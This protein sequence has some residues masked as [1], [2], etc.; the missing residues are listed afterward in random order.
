MFHLFLFLGNIPGV[1]NFKTHYDG[2]LHLET[3][4]SFNSLQ[5]RQVTMLLMLTP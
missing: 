5:A 1:L 4:P 3:M 2:V